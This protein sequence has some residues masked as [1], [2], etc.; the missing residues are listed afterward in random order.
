MNDI[1]NFSRKNTYTGNDS[2]KL[3]NDV[4]MKIHHIGYATCNIPH[5]NA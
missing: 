5:M 2:V 1:N 4:G 3:G